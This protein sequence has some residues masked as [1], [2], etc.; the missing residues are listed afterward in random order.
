VRR[1]RWAAIVA[2]V[3]ALFAPL[4]F[5][6]WGLLTSAGLLLAFWIFASTATLLVLRY[7]AQPA[8]LGAFGRLRSMGN[9]FF[10]MLLAH[11]GIGVFIVGV[12]MVKSYESERDLRMAPGETAEMGGYRFR[13]D[14]VRE[15]QGPNY[16]AARGSVA[17]TRG[18]DLVASLTPEKRVYRVQQNPMTE[19][20]I[21]AGVT[22]DLYVSLGESL[23]GG[24]WT[25]RIHVKPF[26]RWIWIGCLLMAFGG[27]LAASDRRYRVASRERAPTAD[28][29]L[30][31][32]GA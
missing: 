17:V 19:A 3:G 18:G 31:R 1:L 2:L 7:R 6:R 30:V 9:A 27:L 26:V 11:L 16:V 13:F 12:T 5:G 22:R 32:S 29:T 21:N 23:E 28:A 24:A 10:G 25:I 8:A 14:G 15:V 20:A 4:A